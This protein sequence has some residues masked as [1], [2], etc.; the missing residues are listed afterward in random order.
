[1]IV[2]LSGPVTSSVQ[3]I[4]YAYLVKQSKA[5]SCKSGPSASRDSIQERV[6]KLAANRQPLEGCSSVQAAGSDKKDLST[7]VS[8]KGL[9]RSLHQ[10][11]TFEKKWHGLHGY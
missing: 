11:A 1:M 4:G 10:F 9:G 7:M 3:V 5:A 2:S 8:D 6:A